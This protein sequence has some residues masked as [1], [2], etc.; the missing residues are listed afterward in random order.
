M[1]RSGPYTLRAQHPDAI[2]PGYP[3]GQQ[4]VGQPIRHPAQFTIADD[5]SIAV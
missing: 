3:T 5:E 1:R 2:A 4:M